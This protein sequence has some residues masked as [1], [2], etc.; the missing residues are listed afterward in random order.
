MKDHDILCDSGSL[1][2]LTSSCLDGLLYFFSEKYGV[3][4]IIPPSVEYETVKRP[5]K[6]NLRKYLFSA[7]RIKNAIEDGVLNVVDA[8]VTDKTRRLMNMANNMLY[9]RGKPI[10]LIQQ[11]ETEMLALSEEL[12]IDHILIDERTAR[13][14]IEAPF[15]LKEHLQDEFRV[16]VMINKKNLKE[17]SSHISA[18]KAIR[19]SELVMLAYEQGYFKTFENMEKRALEAAL[20]STKYS[21]CSI[22]FDEI[23]DYLS[24]V[25]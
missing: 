1:I 18:L 20:Y 25:K 15:R 16:N 13:M 23:G 6:S 19:S 9:A 8:D 14:L 2:S 22:G 5:I 11:G 17:L 21:G 7:I 24:S 12:G 4:F 3:R 10:R